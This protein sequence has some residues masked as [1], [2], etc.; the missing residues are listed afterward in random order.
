MV[1]ADTSWLTR[2]PVAHRGF[3]DKAAGRIEN[4]LSAADAAIARGFSIEIDLQPS[5]DGVPMVFH[6]DTLD[7]LTGE[8]GL[9]RERPAEALGRIAIAG[10]PDHIPTFAELLARVA[11]RVG[12]VVEVKSDFSGSTDIVAPIAAQLRAYDGPAVIMSFDPR[13]L[14]AFKAI[15][16]EIPRGMLADAT[17]NE[18]E[19]A[20]LSARQRFMQRHLCYATKIRP[21]FAAYHVKALPAPG[22]WALRHLFGKPLL[23]WTVRSE[24][25]RATAR[26]H[27]DQMIFEG[28]DPEA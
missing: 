12:L 24:Q 28:F 23:T 21:A 2:R 10:G 11:G 16:P 4:T 27:A 7:R 8:T 26:R 18:D 15:A 25:D 13:I 14:L 22:P 17:P 19:Y 5:A 6:D 1:A 3:H 9:L 20:A